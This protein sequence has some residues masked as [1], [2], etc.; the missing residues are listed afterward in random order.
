MRAVILIRLSILGFKGGHPSTVTLPFSWKEIRIEY[1]N[2]VLAVIINLKGT[3]LVVVFIDVLYLF[4]VYSI[5]SLR[6][7]KYTVQNLFKLKIRL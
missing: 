6:D 2:Q 7:G 5:Q 1:G 3:H 4:E